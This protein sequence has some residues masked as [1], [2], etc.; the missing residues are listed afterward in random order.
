MFLTLLAEEIPAQMQGLKT[1]Q[2]S[3]SIIGLAVELVV[4][5]S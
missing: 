2:V 4:I 1:S 5:F 3:Y